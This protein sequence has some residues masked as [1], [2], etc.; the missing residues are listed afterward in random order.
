VSFDLSWL[1]RG[2]GLAAPDFEA[3]HRLITIICALHVP[4]LVVYAIA[5]GHTFDTG[6]ADA[7]PVAVLLVAALV[8]GARLRRSLAASLGLLVSSAVLV[9]L[10]GGMV[11]LHFHYFV[12]VAIIALYQDWVVYAAAIGF[13]LI[14]HGLLGELDHSSR[15]DHSGNPWTQ[16]VVHAGFVSALAVA[17]LA[18]WHYQER[19][20]ANEEH[21]RRELYEG[22]QSLVAQLE[23]AAQVRSDLIGTVTHEFR[24]PLTG[25]SGALL[26][27]RRRRHRLDD[28]KT[29]DLLDAAL[30]HADRLRRLL[31]NMLTAAE[32]TAVDPSAVADVTASV[33]EVLTTVA[34][35]QRERILLD[36]PEALPAHI[37]RGALHQVLANLIDN[38]LSHSWPGTTIHLSA[39]RIGSDAVLRLRNT[40]RELDAATVARLLEP[41]TQGDGSPTR[42]RE[43][44]GMGLYVV[45]RL[46]EVHGGQVS[47]QSS[48]GNVTV[49]VNLPASLVPDSPAELMPGAGSPLER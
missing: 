5:T 46:V 27:L 35:A 29:D 34:P 41:F 31:E 48:D 18:F 33:Y 40:G 37:G 36:L 6:L 38:A 25:I 9:H 20:K 16:A 2:R 42:S 3:R 45:R 28:A 39:G 8:P 47:L 26:T 19:A 24:T 22:Q 1:P 49:E 32:A 7:L 15:Y 23:D 44:A 10:S 17:Q 13:V 12:A 4:A 30:L 14:E 21:Y 11:E 43:G